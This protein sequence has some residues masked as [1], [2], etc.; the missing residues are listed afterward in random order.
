MEKQAVFRIK[1]STTSTFASEVKE[2]IEKVR[3]DVGEVRD[4][5][6]KV[7]DDVGKVLDDVGKVLDD[8]EKLKN[9]GPVRTMQT[10][11]RK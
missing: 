4:E 8:V 1:C 7:R 2:D 6:G 5:V 11:R 10:Q 3:D 9:A